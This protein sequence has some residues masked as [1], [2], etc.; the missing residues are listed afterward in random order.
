MLVLVVA[1]FVGILFAFFAT[2]NIQGIP[3]I[4]GNYTIENVPIYLVMLIPLAIGIL[5]ALFMR[6]PKDLSQSLTASEHKDELKKL[7]VELAE[8]TKKAHKFE[9]ENAKLRTELGAPED[10]NSL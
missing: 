2:Q 1:V 8:V 7:K 5:V 4:F 9:V 3:L 10:E 6:I